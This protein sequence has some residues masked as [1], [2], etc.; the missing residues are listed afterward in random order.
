MLPAVEVLLLLALLALVAA[1][2]WLVR[3]AR[4]MHGQPVGALRMLL[5]ARDRRLWWP[6][7]EAPVPRRASTSRTAIART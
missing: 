5:T 4:P 2:L 7:L 3:N 1:G 6:D